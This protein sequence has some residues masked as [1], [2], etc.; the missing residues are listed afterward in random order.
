MGSTRED[1]HGVGEGIE[2]DIVA[3]VDTR[4]LRIQGPGD[5][6]PPFLSPG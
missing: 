6:K 3:E 5:G 2:V 4:T 1:A